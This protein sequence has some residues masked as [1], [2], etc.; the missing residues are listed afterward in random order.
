MKKRWVYVLLCV[1]L[2]PVLERERRAIM[3]LGAWSVIEDGIT[4][5]SV[6]ERPLFV[7]RGNGTGEE[8]MGWPGTITSIPFT[9]RLNLFSQLEI[10]ADQ[11]FCDHAAVDLTDACLESVQP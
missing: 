3:I 8:L 10:T 9:Y 4:P 1:L 5:D 11:T 6:A 2:L 7:F